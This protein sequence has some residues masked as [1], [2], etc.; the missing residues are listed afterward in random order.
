MNKTQN[1]N[2]LNIVHY[3]KPSLN[4]SRYAEHYIRNLYPGD[5]GNIYMIGDNPKSDIRGG[6]AAGWK[7]ILLRTGVFK[8]DND[9]LD[10]ATYV[11]DD[12]A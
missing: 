11:V 4:T 5:L 1:N 10:P 12:I 7:T 3:G 8:G 6:N 9:A 2:D